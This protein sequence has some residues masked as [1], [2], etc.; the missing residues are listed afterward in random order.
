MTSLSFISSEKSIKKTIN[1]L[2]ATSIGFSQK[3]LIR[4]FGMEEKCFPT[5]YTRKFL[6][7]ITGTG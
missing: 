2:V 4:I 1:R 5:A 3:M 6:L 7:R